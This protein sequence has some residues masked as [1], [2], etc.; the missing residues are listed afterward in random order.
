MKS[1]LL[2]YKQDHQEFKGFLAYPDVE[3]KSPAVLIIHDWSGRNQFAD[4]KALALAELGYVGFA[5]DL[6]GE[7]KLGNTI[8]EK[9]ALMQPLASD[10][11]LIRS[12]L[13]NALKLL[14]AFPQVDKSKIAVIGFCFGGLCALELAR[15]GEDILGT[16]TF[17]G[18]LNQDSTIETKAIRSKII[19]FH[20]YDD[21][22]VPPTVIEQFAAEMTNANADW[23]LHAYGQT[24]HAFTNPN[25]H[26]TKLGLIYNQTARDRSWES[27]KNFL[28]EIFK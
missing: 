23:Q 20:G 7:G 11:H 5:V 10:R 1:E 9:K 22:M 6:Y 26:D 2:T 8:E 25:A 4:D 28:L 17:H 18:L 13:Q 3:C 24:Q 21:P 15:S 19:A 27:F 16:V 12:R 14:K